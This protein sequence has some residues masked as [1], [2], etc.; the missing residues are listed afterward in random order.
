MNLQLHYIAVQDSWTHFSQCA[1]GV[2]ANIDDL[3]VAYNDFFDLQLLVA[4][5]FFMLYALALVSS[6][7]QACGD[8]DVA[9]AVAIAIAAGGHWIVSSCLLCCRRQQ[10]QQQQLQQQQQQQKQLL[11]VCSFGAQGE[12]ER[13]ELVANRWQWRLESRDPRCEKPATAATN[14]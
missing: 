13:L 1:A 11:F 5:R 4:L 14:L 9:V 10:Q 3:V 7:G 6:A 2:A 8:A 12:A